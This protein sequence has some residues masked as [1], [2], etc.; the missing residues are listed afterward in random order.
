MKPNGQAISTMM[1]ACTT[2]GA[3]S[4]SA[5]PT[6]SDERESGATSVRSCEPV[7]ISY[8]RFDPVAP[9]PNSTIITSTPGTNHCRVSPAG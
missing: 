3:I 9:V 2:I 8:C 7:I 6:R 5:R 1:I 4:L